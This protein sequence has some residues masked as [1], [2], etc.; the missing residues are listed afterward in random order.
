M[1]RCWCSINQHLGSC[2][3]A[4]LHMIV[5]KYHCGMPALRYWPLNKFPPSMNTY[6]SFTMLSTDIVQIKLIQVLKHILT[7]LL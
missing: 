3:V 2:F 7:G 4:G 5:E 1:T 6:C